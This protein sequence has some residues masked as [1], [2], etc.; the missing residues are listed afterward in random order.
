MRPFGKQSAQNRQTWKPFRSSAALNSRAPEPSAGFLRHPWSQRR[1]SPCPGGTQGA[2]SP[3]SCG[4]CAAPGAAGVWVLNCSRC[5]AFLQLKLSQVCTQCF[6]SIH[7]KIPKPLPRLL[8]KLGPV[9][10]LPASKKNFWRGGCPYGCDMA[11]LAWWAWSCGVMGMKAWVILGDF[12]I[13][14]TTSDF[15]CALRCKAKKA[16]GSNP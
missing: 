6:T 5:R 14:S 15:C 12:P 2:P 13:A 3:T 7:E 16:P 9:S 8:L 4:Q 10:L 1:G 11:Q